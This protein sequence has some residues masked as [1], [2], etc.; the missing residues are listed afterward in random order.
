[1]IP[2]MLTWKKWM[3]VRPV[4]QMEIIMDKMQ[5]CKEERDLRA[6]LMETTGDLS[7]TPD[8]IWTRRKKE[9]LRRQAA[10]G[11]GRGRGL[12]RYKGRGPHPS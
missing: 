2:T 5:M 6:K 3:K 9:R 10:K 12:R 1:M 8:A 11:R 4:E 7:M